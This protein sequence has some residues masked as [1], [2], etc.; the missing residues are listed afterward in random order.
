MEIDTYVQEDD[1][2]K[3]RILDTCKRW[4]T[5]D[6]RTGEIH[7][8]DVLDPR[9]AVLRRVYGSR[10][11]EREITLFISGR[12]YHEIMEALVAEQQV[13]R[14][15]EV[16][17]QGVVGHID[18]T[19]E[20][21]PFEFKSSRSWKPSPVDNLSK[22]Y[23]RNLGYYV[24]LHSPDK[25]LDIGRLGILYVAAKDKVTGG[26]PLKIYTV[27][28]NNLAAIRED[29]LSRK[30]AIVDVLYGNGKFSDLPD[31]NNAEYDNWSMC[32]TCTYSAEC[33]KHMAGGL[34]EWKMQNV[35]A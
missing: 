1:A 35:Q 30:N 7:I 32:E 22:R 31:C 29:V 6:D 2:T 25:E 24:A 19:P 8:S 12:S 14:E 9:Q 20:G 23:I 15:V 3:T 33:G 10:L 16:R 4:L 18:A 34:I 21:V 17:W 27:T 26:P 5:K 13:Q 28:Y 11:G